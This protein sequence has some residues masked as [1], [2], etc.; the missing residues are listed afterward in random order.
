MVDAWIALEDNQDY[1]DIT[2]TAETVHCLSRAL[3]D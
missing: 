3:Q 1:M 2:E